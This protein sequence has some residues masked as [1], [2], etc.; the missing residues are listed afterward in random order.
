MATQAFEYL[1]KA[2]LAATS[3]PLGCSNA[4]TWELLIDGQ[5]PVEALQQALRWLCVAYPTCAAIVV[6]HDGTPETAK[7]FQWSWPDSAASGA[8]QS[9]DH[10]LEFH[11]LR[12]AP[13][14]AADHL[15]DGVHDR[16]L[17]LFKRPP[18]Q[19]ILAW[20]PE[21]RA[22]L[23]VKQHHG[24]ADGRAMIEM[25]PDLAAFLNHA[26]AGTQPDAQ[27]LQVVPR[28]AEL[29]AFDLTP[30]QRRMLLLG[31]IGE[32]VQSA[33]VSLRRPLSV[34]KQN[35]SL[36]YSG[37]NRTLHVPIDPGQ[38]QAWK[39]AAKRGGGNLNWMMAA[40][41]MVANKRW[42][43]AQGVKITRMNAT[44]AAETRPR[45][46]NWRSFANHLAFH[47]PDI[48]FT[49]FHAVA[50]VMPEIQRQVQAQNARRAHLKRYLFERWFALTLK[51]ADF[52]K[53][54]F[55]SPRTVVNLNFSNVLAIP[56]PR[57]HGPG[58]QVTDVRVATPLIPRTAIVLTLTNYDGAATLN[59]NYKASVAS[60][61]EV[62]Q[63]VEVFHS[64]VEQF[65]ASQ[66][67]AP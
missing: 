35:A 26:L 15:R 16:F 37:G 52:R 36:D 2:C 7:N 39:E 23:F 24:L 10:M 20:L 9:L 12:M 5:P 32:Y 67:V 14:A 54:L 21:N 57:L 43:E 44:T 45:G 8:S 22:R 38:L 19:L 42:N 31:G 51:M 64:E 17:D 49:R 34:L 18:L 25:L 60:H 56:I 61:A 59:F 50:D 66:A 13:A 62:A 27:Q 1:D 6:P 29:D 58:W 53:L 63:L 41:F 11:D 40:A 33:F 46:Q 4:P 47:I 3:G 30:W 28:R 65:V 48:D 55:A